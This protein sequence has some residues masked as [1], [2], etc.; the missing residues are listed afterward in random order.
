MNGARPSPHSRAR[1]SAV[2]LGLALGASCSNFHTVEPGRYYR[3]GQPGAEELQTW[4]ETYGL[5]TVIR[6]NGGSPGN[7]DYDSSHDPVVAAGATFFHVPM[8]ATRY[9]SPEDLLTLWEIFDSAEY[10]LLV[11]CRA[12]ADRTGL[13]S[14][15]YVLH[16]TGDLRQA[17]GQLDFFP[18]LHVGWAGTW[19]MDRILDLYEPYAKRIS[20][21]DWV[22]QE[23]PRLLP[24]R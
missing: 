17:R 3:S 10:P 8:S 12:G 18:Y 15:I 9:P 6:L 14:A 23:Y 24:H 22:R 5:K 20:F 7:S 21:P 1:W 16:S 11:H 13:A 19:I 4:I 2:V